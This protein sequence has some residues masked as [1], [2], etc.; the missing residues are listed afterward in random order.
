MGQVLLDGE[1]CVLDDLGRSDF[2]RLQDRPLA[3]Q[4]LLTFDFSEVGRITVR[5]LP[6]RQ[7]FWLHAPTLA[8]QTQE[9][10]GRQ[11]VWPTLLSVTFNAAILWLA[12]PPT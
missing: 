10:P 1:A 11:A 8:A 3:V 9:C 7:I 2:N 5:Q 6:D 4:V 12:V